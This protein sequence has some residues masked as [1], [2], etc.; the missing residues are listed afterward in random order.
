M[1]VQKSIIRALGRLCCIEYYFRSTG[2]AVQVQQSNTGALVMLCRY[3]RV[4]LE[5][6]EGCDGTDE[7][8]RRPGEAVW[9]SRVL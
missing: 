9:Y 7:Y 2:E 3:R 1:L 6:S 8:S 5:H 4:L